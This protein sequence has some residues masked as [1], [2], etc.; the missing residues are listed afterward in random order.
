METI[1]IKIF[2]T[3]EFAKVVK[4]VRKYQ[5]L[6]ISEIKNRIMQSEYIILCDGVDDEG[7]AVIISLYNELSALNISC[8]LFEDDSPTDIHLL[9]NLQEMYC[10]IDEYIDKYT[11]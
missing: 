3:A 9:C 2:P 6:S 10:E 8:E 11:E 4:I 5:N 7:L 1:G